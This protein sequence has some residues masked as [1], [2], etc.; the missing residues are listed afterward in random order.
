[1]INTKTVSVQYPQPDV[2]GNY[3]AIVIGAGPAGATT[4]AL[5]AKGGARTLLL[6]R[7]AIP[8]FH[9]G[10]SLISRTF[11][12]LDELD[13]VDRLNASSFPRK[14][15]VQF[16]AENGKVTAP[17]YFD[18]YIKHESSVTW[19]V[20]RGVFDQLLVERA[21]ELGA[22]IRQ[23]AHVM[24]VLYNEDGAV[25]GVKVKLGHG[26][27]HPAETRSIHAR[28]VVDAT[29]QSSFLGNRLG[30][31]KKD[32][33]LQKATIW[34]YFENAVRDEGKDEGATIIMQTPGKK[35]WFWY[36]PLSNNIVSVGCTG[37]M[38]YMTDKSRGGIEAVF[39]D[40]LQRC[41]EMKRR[42]EPAT[43]VRDFFTTK[44]FSYRATQTAGDG[45]CLVG[46]A[47]GFIDPV[48]SS[49]VLLAL[50]SGKFAADA[51]LQ[52]LA[53]NDVSGE[54]LGAWNTSYCRGLENFKRLVYAFYAPDFS[55]G[56]FF[57]KFPEHRNRMT[58][59]LMGDVFRPEVEAIFEDMGDVMPP[60]D[61]QE[62]CVVSMA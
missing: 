36:I 47:F 21:S 7:S 22:T 25:S 20:E 33:R 59:I 42:L 51:I 39:N 58:D 5:L 1:M 17:F 40:E 28:V 52:G 62:E 24:D 41:A 44:D 15:S 23:D 29:G 48:Y 12:V 6:E 61:L 11:D 60:S 9:V 56:S 19:Q 13:L 43:R 4:A 46:D 57:M 34:T 53:N 38:R 31:I 50:K 3:D 8:R 10:E 30:V 14:Y 55:F 35:T 27:D 26:P 18:D 2:S 32:D 54:Q 16:V 37:S 45:W 49:G